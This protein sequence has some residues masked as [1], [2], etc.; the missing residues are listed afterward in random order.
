MPSGTKIT[1]RAFYLNTSI[2]RLRFSLTTASPLKPCRNTAKNGIVHHPGAAPPGPRAFLH[3]FDFSRLN[4]SILISPCAF[5]VLGKEGKSDSQVTTVS[6]VSP[7]PAALAA[8]G[9]VGVPAPNHRAHGTR[10]WAE[11]ATAVPNQLSS[12]EI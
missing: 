5:S 6:P 12:P 11:T 1:S 4:L 2:T 3:L 8:L 10:L 7:F 9:R